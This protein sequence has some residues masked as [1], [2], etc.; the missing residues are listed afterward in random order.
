VKA[1]D[2]HA[3]RLFGTVAD[4]TGIMPFMDLAQRVMTLEPY[5][6]ARRVYWVV[7]DG[8][9]HRGQRSTPRTAL[10][11]ED[12]ARTIAWLLHGP[13]RSSCTCLPMPRG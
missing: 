1:Y 3:G 6:S 10:D 13:T 2:V 7:D 11:T 12:S 4:E 5:A 8:S 9:S